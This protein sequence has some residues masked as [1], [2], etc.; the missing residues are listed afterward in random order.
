M[1]HVI[2][3]ADVVNRATNVAW[4]VAAVTLLV[5]LARSIAQARRY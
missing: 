1:E 5:L 3:A 2:I 4:F